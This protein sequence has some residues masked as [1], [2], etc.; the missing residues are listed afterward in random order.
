[1]PMPEGVAGSVVVSAPI[2][3]LS[4]ARTYHFRIV[5]TNSEGTSKGADETFAT[6]PLPSRAEV[7]PVVPAPSSVGLGPPFGPITPA[8]HTLSLPS[9]LGT[10]FTM[11]SSRVER[12]VLACPP[13]GDSCVGAIV[14]RV[15][16][17]GHRRVVRAGR[18]HARSGE[19]LPIAWG[20]YAIVP[21]R[22]VS[23][24][25]VVSAQGRWLLSVGHSLRGQAALRAEAPAGAT[26]VRD[27]AV[28]FA[29][30]SGTRAT[31]SARRPR[32]ALSSG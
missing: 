32:Q 1:M 28:T 9:L 25:L 10:I 23:V 14:L 27:V 2:G 29:T 21:G 11:S 19:L 30:R 6:Q 15:A 17:S 20:R 3:G 12:V 31:G 26:L 7:P 5:A 16:S 13:G 18:P 22:S 24:A 8:R 4:A